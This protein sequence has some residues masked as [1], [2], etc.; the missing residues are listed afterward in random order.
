MSAA[1]RYTLMFCLIQQRQVDTKDQL[2]DLFLR[3]IRKTRLSAEKKLA[4]LQELFRVIEEQ[5]LAIFSQVAGYTI[6]ISTDKPLG[7]SVR[8]LMEQHG[9]AVYL[10]D[11]YQQV[12]A[13]HNKNSLP[14]LWKSLGAFHFFALGGIFKKANNSVPMPTH[15]KCSEIE[16][17]N[18]TLF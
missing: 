5:L 15:I 16:H 18:S 1:K 11:Q 3:R 12:A 13:Y 6:E 4:V 7:V 14:L 17:I 8:T 10:L 9:G 2:A